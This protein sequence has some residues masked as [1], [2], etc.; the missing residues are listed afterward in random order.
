M[1]EAS[2]TLVLD[3]ILIESLSRKEQDHMKKSI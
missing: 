1:Y 2:D 3:E